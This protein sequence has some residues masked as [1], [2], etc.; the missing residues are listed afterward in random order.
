MSI[1]PRRFRAEG[2]RARRSAAFGA[3]RSRR[4]GA[5]IR[6]EVL[7][8]RQLLSGLTLTSAGRADGFSLS[9]FATGFPV[10]SSIGPMGIVFPPGGGVL[11][12]DASGNVRRFAS[13]AVGQSAA[14]TPPVAGASD[15]A[16]NGA[17]LARVGANLYLMM[18]TLGEIA[19]LNGNGTVKGV[20][21]HGT[22]P[23]GSRSTR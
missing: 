10:A 14:A 17:G 20:M 21:A 2:R 22:A 16:G 12:S 6:V 4:R 23:L 8:S 3:E 1:I 9:T 11:V 5:P 15:G 13:D 18:P 7:E 19:Q